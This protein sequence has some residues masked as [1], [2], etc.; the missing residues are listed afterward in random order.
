VKILAVVFLLAIAAYIVMRRRRSH[1]SAGRQFFS[2][3]HG[4]N[5]KNGDGS[6][7]QKIIANCSEGEELDLVPE[8]TNRYDSGAVMIC[9]KNGEQ[10]GYWQA[11]RM[12]RD[13]A[14]GWTYR[15]TIDE[16]YMFREDRKKH[17]VRLRVEVLTMSRVTEAR[18]QKRADSSK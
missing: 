4:I 7:R 15:V 17:G 14:A 12:A 13:L 3:V 18:K 10:L 1:R 16:I 9:R 2:Q 8:P 5:H 6:S 11:G